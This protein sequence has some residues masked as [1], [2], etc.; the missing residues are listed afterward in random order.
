MQNPDSGPAERLDLGVG[1]KRPPHGGGFEASRKLSRTVSA[2]NGQS[3]ERA[4][5][6]VARVEINGL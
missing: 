5:T 2:E 4:L 1:A 3:P 6:S